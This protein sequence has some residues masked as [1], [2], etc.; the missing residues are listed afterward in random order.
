MLLLFEN[1]S[2]S[3][4][5]LSSKDNRTIRHILKD[6]QKNKCVCFHENLQLIKMKMEMK[7]DNT[8]TT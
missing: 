5:T 6:K 8:D 1:Y 3:S 4:S 2:Q 7:T